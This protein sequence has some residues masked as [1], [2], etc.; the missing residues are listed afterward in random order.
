[1]VTT[2]SVKKDLSILNAKWLIDTISGDNPS[3]Y[4][5]T[6]IGHA[7]E[8][9]T[10]AEPPYPADDVYDYIQEWKNML[11]LKPVLGIDVTLAIRKVQW[12]TGTVYDI[13][14]DQDPD[15][16]DK[17][18]Y[19]I[20]S[21]NKVYKCLSNN[22][23][24]PSTQEP[25]SS[26][27]TPFTTTDNYKWQLMYTISADDLEKWSNDYVIPVKEITSDDSSLQ[28]QIQE[29]AI[30]GTID[31]IIID[32]PGNGYL[33]APT[34][35][36]TG[37]G[38]GATAEAILEGDSISRILITNRGQ[39]Y[40][41]ATVSV[42]GNATL[43]PV[44]SPV[45]GHGSNAVEELVGRYIIIRTIFDKDESGNFPVDVS[46]RQI[47][48]VLNPTLQGTEDIAKETAAINQMASLTLNIEPSSFI[49]GEQILNQNNNS[50][51]IFVNYN[52]NNVNITDVNGT[53][54][55]G[56][57]IVGVSSGSSATIDSYQKPYL[58]LYSGS[59]LYVENRTP[60][61]RYSTQ[62]ETYRLVIA[63]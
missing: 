50:T 22:N 32:N 43:Q 4:L 40:T 49:P 48:L 23:G 25:D 58:N 20:T 8:W 18:Y 46:Y 15:L 61:P 51:A 14:N 45:K 29:A 34:I 62:T 44:I 26:A 27:L 33:V 60:T 5:Y 28:W 47:G 57:T 56:D 16:N 30:P 17:D 1:M 53:F 6:F 54:N 35:T 24:Q 7:Q 36:I 59:M 31:N 19:V 37:D 2:F 10:D 52:G 39:G 13:Y 21:N 42:T 12:T 55:D 11:A 41:T 9:P 3:N 38:T 63:F